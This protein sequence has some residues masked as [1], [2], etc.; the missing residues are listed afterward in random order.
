MKGKVVCGKCGSAAKFWPD[1]HKRRIY[2]CDKKSRFG[3]K[4]CDCESVNKQVVYDIV[5][6]VL[7]EE[8][9]L[10][11][12]QDVV[13]ASLSRSNRV[14]EKKKL[15]VEALDKCMKESERVR[16][17]KGALYR[18]F[19]DGLLNESEYLEINREYTGQ[20]DQIAGQI[21][22]YENILQRLDSNPLA[23]ENIKELLM[24]FTRKRRLS[25]E[26]V[27]A[28]VEKVVIHEGKRLEVVLKFEDVKA[29][30]LQRRAEME[31]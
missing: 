23:E 26:M 21:K 12:E 15:Y 22:D 30:L 19:V 27:D 5:F 9:Q 8:M 16:T 2:V 31:G 18:D 3:K 17:Q 4:A 25:Q 7:K 11:L 10:M 20:L 14:Q 24:K 29:K 6:N 28:L 13:I 1:H